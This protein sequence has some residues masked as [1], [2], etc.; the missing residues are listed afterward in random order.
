MLHFTCNIPKTSQSWPKTP[1]IC[2]L[3]I[4]Y[5]VGSELNCD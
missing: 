3:Y 5:Y 4:L 2:D 1:I